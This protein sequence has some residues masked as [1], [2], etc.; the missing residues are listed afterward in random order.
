MEQE[1]VATNILLAPAVSARLDA[2]SYTIGRR[3]GHA[4]GRAGVLAAAA[5]ALTR[6]G[7]EIT[8]CASAAEISEKIAAALTAFNE[9]KEGR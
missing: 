3:T 1:K 2:M 9:E 4:P 8:A 7:V 6:A 5:A